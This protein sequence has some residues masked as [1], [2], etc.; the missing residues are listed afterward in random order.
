MLEDDN[1]LSADELQKLIFHMCHM[2]VRCTKTISI[3]APVAYAD[4]V[5]YRA[6]KHLD[7][8]NGSDSGSSDCS[9]TYRLTQEDINAI[10]VV[11][12]FKNSMYFV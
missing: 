12:R 4:L 5:A 2:Y 9:R 7:C 10:Q 11:D 3:P 1:D 6:R 8:K